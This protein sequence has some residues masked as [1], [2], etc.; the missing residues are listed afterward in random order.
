MTKRAQFKKYLH[1]LVEI[2]NIMTAMEN[3]TFIEIN[4]L[5][6][7]TKP[8]TAVVKSIEAVGIDF[9]TFYPQLLPVFSVNQ[10]DIEILIGSERGFCG[11]FNESIIA[12]WHLARSQQPR[13]NQKI[14]IVGQKLANKLTGMMTADKAEVI[15][16]PSIAEEIPSVISVLIERIKQMTAEESEQSEPLL[17][18]NSS[19]IFNTIDNGQ[20]Y[21]T[22]LNP[23]SS[24]H[25]QPL[26]SFAYEPIINT[27]PDEFLAEYLVYFF[28]A[29][30]HHVFYQSMMSENEK[31]FQHVNNAKLRLQRRQM[32]LAHAIN[33]LRQ[34]EIIEEI[35]NILLSVE[36]KL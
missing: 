31:R 12:K 25:Q 16:G 14:I 34:E 28:M 24:L 8:L 3:L 33:R 18:L 1:A 9:L 13:Q 11:N 15:A 35:E 2:K 17:F 36:L 4:K 19:I 30:L 27:S 6:K 26:I 5:T 22:L 23:L 20:V 7:Y 21:A 32:R 29:N 10:P